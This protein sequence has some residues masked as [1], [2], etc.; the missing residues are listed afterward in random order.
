MGHQ[1]W[2]D[3]L[4]IR[5]SDNAP[6][7]CC[8]VSDSRGCLPEQSVRDTAS[9]F[10]RNHGAKAFSGVN[11]RLQAPDRHIAAG[12]RHKETRESGMSRGLSNDAASTSSTA[13]GQDHLPSA[14]APP[15]GVNSCASALRVRYS[16]CI[17][18]TT[19]DE[20]MRRAPAN[21]CTA[22]SRRRSATERPL[23]IV[24]E[25][26]LILESPFRCRAAGDHCREGGQMRQ[27]AILLVYRYPSRHGVAVDLRVKRAPSALRL[28]EESSSRPSHRAALPRRSRHRESVARVDA[29]VRRAEA[30]CAALYIYL[31]R[32]SK[33]GTNSRQFQFEEFLKASRFARR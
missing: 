23:A 20:S 5:E 3:R 25:L 16:V 12:H 6:R 1:V 13:G 22:D 18:E 19:S 21:V 11:L 31:L 33:R 8:P 10:E 27:A 9:S 15:P 28:E 30:H 2:V 17:S 32:R 24:F 29:A 14:A 4:R 7:C 26:V